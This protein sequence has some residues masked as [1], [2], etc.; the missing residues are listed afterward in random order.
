[1]AGLS[2]K[3]T[4]KK[5][6]AGEDFGDTGANNHLHPTRTASR[7]GYATES[8]TRSGGRSQCRT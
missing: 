1:M 7:N 3:R 2:G 5:Y 4:T 8:T 6:T